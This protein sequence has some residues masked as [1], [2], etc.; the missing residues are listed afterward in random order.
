MSIMY[1]YYYL[2]INSSSLPISSVVVLIVA[3]IIICDVRY[4]VSMSKECGNQCVIASLIL[5]SYLSK[6][7]TIHCHDMALRTNSKCMTLE[8]FLL[9]ISFLF[10]R[11]IAAGSWLSTR[12]WITYRQPFCVCCFCFALLICVCAYYK[13]ETP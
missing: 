3:Y 13:L 6:K 1:Y 10:P 12:T 2:W 5:Y 11:S 7:P 8:T 9:T 4:L